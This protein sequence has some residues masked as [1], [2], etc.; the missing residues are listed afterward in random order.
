MKKKTF[1]TFVTALL[2][3]ISSI[4]LFAQAEVGVGADFVNR[5]IWRGL[6]LGTA[7][8]IQPTLALTTGGFEV[9]AWG[10]YQI[11][12]DESSLP[13]DE[14]DIYLGYTFDV[15]SS[16]LGIILTD[17]Y[18]P[19]GSF[20]FGDFDGD[21]NGG[22]TIELGA[23][24]S[25]PESFPFYISGYV[26]IH[27][28]PDY[29]SYFELGY[30]STVNDVGLDLFLGVTPGGDGAYYGTKDFNII[31]FGATASKEIKITDDFALPVF[32]SLIF[33]PKQEIAYL[34]F[35]ITI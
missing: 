25:G 26:N 8:S 10:S 35:G 23:I 31:N 16:S 4:N 28:D 18:Y 22:H 3:F 6:D 5:Y 14:I 21:G 32:S 20:K 13:A 2:I 27:N 12:R 9:G 15:G 30:S 11:G 19:N 17:Y 1:N 29:S 34:V 7:A 33:N 24:F